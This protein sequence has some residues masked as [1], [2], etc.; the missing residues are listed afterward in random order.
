[1]TSDMPAW[2]AW[3]IIAAIGCLIAFAAYVPSHRHRRSPVFAMFVLGMT[4]AILCVSIVR[5]CV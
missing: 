3:L 5:G 1:M 4:V 2:V